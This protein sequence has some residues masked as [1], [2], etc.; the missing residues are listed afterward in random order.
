M[1]KRFAEEQVI[2]VLN[3]HEARMLIE[4]WPQDCNR[5]RPYSSMNYHDTHG[6]CGR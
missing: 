6:F 5:V 3:E 2:K 1:K 4:D